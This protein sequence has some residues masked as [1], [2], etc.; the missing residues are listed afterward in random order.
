MGQ[1]MTSGKDGVKTAG[2]RGGSLRSSTTASIPA[3]RALSR[4]TNRPQAAT[5]DFVAR[6]AMFQ[7]TASSFQS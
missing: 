4:L 6:L 7:R 5:C 2:W 1:A 3:K